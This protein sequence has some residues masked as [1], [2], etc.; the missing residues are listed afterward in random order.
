MK[1][2]KPRQLRPRT[3]AGLS[4]IAGRSMRRSAFRWCDYDA[5]PIPYAEVKS[6][7][8]R[9]KEKRTEGHCCWN[10]L[11]AYFGNRNERVHALVGDG[12]HGK[13]ERIQDY[14]CQGCGC[15][16]SERKG[17]VMYCLKTASK[18]VAMVLTALGEGLDLSASERVF[19]HRGGDASGGG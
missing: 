14:Q 11:C 17:T 19:G 15:R 1:Q 3:P 6:R 12:H 16:V 8:G 7:R 9:P 18:R 4:R 2:K 10:P 13:G 5:Q